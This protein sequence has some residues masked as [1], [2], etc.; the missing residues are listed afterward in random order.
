MQHNSWT[1]IWMQK[2][3]WA[4]QAWNNKLNLT[5]SNS[6]FRN[7]IGRDLQKGTRNH[8]SAN[9]FYHCSTFCPRS[10]LFTSAM[11]Q[12]AKIKGWILAPLLFL[13]SI[14]EHPVGCYRHII[15]GGTALCEE[16]S[17][18]LRSESNKNI[19]QSPSA[20]QLSDWC[21]GEPWGSSPSTEPPQ[22]DSRGWGATA[23]PRISQ[24]STWG[25]ASPGSVSAQV[26]TKPGISQRCPRVPH[27]C[28][29]LRLCLPRC[30]SSDGFSSAAVPC[31]DSSF[32]AVSR[33]LL[34]STIPLADKS[35]L[36]CYSQD[37][38]CPQNAKMWPLP[39]QCKGKKW[40]FGIISHVQ[41]FW[42]NKPHETTIIK[43]NAF[44]S[45]SLPWTGYQFKL[46][47]LCMENFRN[48]IFFSC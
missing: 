44:D 13:V 45:T 3:L 6:A 14:V 2:M 23:D 40:N 38:S 29:H 27:L 36:P 41:V 11:T 4:Q 5:L 46:I 47:I 33:V 22:P 34:T 39:C 16:R 26:H 9:S 37:Q 10:K 30:F 17:R 43:L 24:P 8:N 7:F 28:C 15:Q 32:G 21:Q 1:G 18:C 42:I 25:G 35:V 48:N 19:L 20:S 12:L 31:P